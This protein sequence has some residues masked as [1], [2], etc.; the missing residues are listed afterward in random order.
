MSSSL[1]LLVV[2]AVLICAGVYLMMERSL[3]RILVGVLMAG[4][5]VNL[6]FLVAS[7]SPGGA[8][9]IGTDKGRD[10]S[11]PLPQAMVLTAI[12]ITLALTA[13]L[14]TMAYRSFQ[15]H[16]HDEVADD[17]EDRQIV[18]LAEADLASASFDEADS[19]LPSED[20]AE[21]ELDEPEETEGD[22]D[23]PESGKADPDKADPDKAEA[24][25]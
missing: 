16:G 17:V 14:L 23:S 21:P 12:V 10:I 13:F 25:R 22:P 19:S 1:T 15:L 5:G 2:A 18:L 4:N 24:G 7:G 6:L 20:D 11:D 8:P 9:F 3:T